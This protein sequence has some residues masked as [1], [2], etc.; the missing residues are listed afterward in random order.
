MPE[1]NKFTQKIKQMGGKYNGVN[2]KIA[3]FEESELKRESATINDNDI[4]GFPTLKLGLVVGGEKKEYEYLK[5][6][7][8][9][10][11]VNYVKK[12]CDGIKNYK[13][14]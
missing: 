4:E 13:K 3:A 5:E 10:M 9:D 11:M 2:I 7:D 12:V 14:K 6:K 8:S 1:W